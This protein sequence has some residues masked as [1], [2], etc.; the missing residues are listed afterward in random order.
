[1]SSCVYFK[2][3]S[4]KDYQRIPFDGTGISVFELKREIIT[5]SRLGDGND[6]DLKLL[7]AAGD[8]GMQFRPLTLAL[9]SILVLTNPNRI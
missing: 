3:K 4:Q 6:F 8:E 9:R 5:L 1:M 7:N 2:F